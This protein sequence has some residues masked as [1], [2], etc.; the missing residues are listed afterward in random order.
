M[1]KSRTPNI[2][3]FYK[4]VSEIEQIYKTKVKNS[5]RPQIKSSKDA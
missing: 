2:W 4:N 5:E 3:N 1:Q